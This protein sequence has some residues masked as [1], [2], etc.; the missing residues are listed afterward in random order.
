MSSQ[1][2]STS[3]RNGKVRK[4]MDVVGPRQA[5]QRFNLAF[6]QFINDAILGEVNSVGG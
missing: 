6:N 5:R 4:T 3:E 1:P 2:D